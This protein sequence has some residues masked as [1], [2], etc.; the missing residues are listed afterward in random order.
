MLDNLTDNLSSIVKK[1]RGQS[2]LTPEN[3]QETA[4]LIRN[5]L[6]DA[7]VALPVVE[8]FIERV[9]EKALGHKVLNS[10]TPGQALIGIVQEEITQLMG[11][12]AVGV[13]MP[14]NDPL[15][16]LLC[17][18]QGSGKTTTTAKLALHL[19]TK[20]KKRVLVASTDVYRPAAIEQL[21]LLCEQVKVDFHEPADDIK[22]DPIAR[23]TTAV[24][25]ASRTL[26]DYVLI[27]SA[28]R[29]VIDD[30]MMKEIKQLAKKTKAKENL[31]V[32]DS[33]QGQEA[34]VVAKKFSDAVPLTGAC[35]SKLDGDAR[36]GA[37]MSVK[38][39]VGI[40]IKFVGVGEKPEDLQP[41]IPERMASRILGMGD[42]VSLVETATAA[43]G[44]KQ[45]DRLERKLRKKKSGGLS[46]TDMIEQMRQAEKM[47]GVDKIADQLPSHL[48]S[49]IKNTN[50]DPKIFKQMEAIY[51]SMTKFER[52]NPGHI[53]GS[54][55]QRIAAGC[56]LEVQQVNQLLAQ[57]SQA[58]KLM[59]KAAKNPVAAMNMMRGIFG[60][61]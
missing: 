10:L 57:H 56:G 58:N 18:L 20:Y 14:G 36:G 39:T 33:T 35:L 44:K 27:D 26:H 49:K 40:P 38:A 24:K 37:A 41:F 45:T 53:K 55:K 11:T 30:A 23:A 3:I 12:E 52:L 7:D 29:N 2:R 60:G 43:M 16:M 51:L 32:I 17:G 28:G 54:R 1:I 31:L 50:I 46:L 22:D 6:I 19:T 8:E 34:I 61:G 13:H 9:T 21:R 47:G 25:S 59:K 15:V 42:I 48:A 5:T 4:Q